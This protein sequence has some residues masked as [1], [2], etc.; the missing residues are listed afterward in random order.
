MFSNYEFDK[1]VGERVKSI[2]KEK[3]L[4]QSELANSIGK[5]QQAIQRLEKGRVTPSIYF[6]Y[7]ICNSLN[8]TI[9]YFFDETFK[10][11]K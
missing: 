7:E 9:N 10:E 3:G 2:R 11:I 8:V 4:S 1:L 6:I 5:D